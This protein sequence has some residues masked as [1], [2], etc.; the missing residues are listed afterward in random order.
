MSQNDQEK[1]AAKYVGIGL[2]MHEEGPHLARCTLYCAGGIKGRAP[3]FPMA[4]S[5]Y[6]TRRR[7]HW[8]KGG[9]TVGNNCGRAK[10][11][12]PFRGQAGSQ[13]IERMRSRGERGR[14]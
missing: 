11:D 4:E 12:L 10:R 5:P 3:L 14:T 7:I 2:D 9:I 13:P 6:K 8:K 1:S